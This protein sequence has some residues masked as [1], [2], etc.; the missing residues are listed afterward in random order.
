MTE[1]FGSVESVFLDGYVELRVGGKK[2]A[3]VSLW[4]DGIQ[5]GG[6]FGLKLVKFGTKE[7]ALRDLAR[8]CFGGAEE[9]GLLALRTIRMRQEAWTEA[10]AVAAARNLVERYERKIGLP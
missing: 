8:K 3:T 2:H 4:R 5:V 6:P 1:M 10:E 9:D 7:K